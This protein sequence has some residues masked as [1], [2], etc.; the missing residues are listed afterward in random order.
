MTL[1]RQTV[2]TRCTMW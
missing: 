2:Q 1:I